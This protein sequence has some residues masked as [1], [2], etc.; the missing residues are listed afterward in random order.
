MSGSS[1]EKGGGGG[2]AH[3]TGL[4]PWSHRAR[5]LAIVSRSHGGRWGTSFGSK[6]E[7][8][9]TCYSFLESRVRQGASGWLSGP[10]GRRCSRRQPL[11]SGRQAEPGLGR[12]AGHISV[13][14]SASGPRTLRLSFSCSLNALGG[15]T[16][17]AN[18]A[19]GWAGSGVTCRLQLS[20]F[21]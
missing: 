21:M 8:T 19:L 14:S 1:R 10:G 20:L 5:M 4:R 2:C 13:L 7:T 11:S 12:P 6:A 9:P 18:P 17:N 3:G 16:H 15:P